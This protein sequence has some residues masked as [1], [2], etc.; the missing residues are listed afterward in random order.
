MKKIKKDEFVKAK[1][2]IKLTTGDVIK[3]LRE[4]KGWTQK[5]LAKK[6]GITDTNISFLE[7]KKIEIGKKRAEQLS[8][9]F[10]VHPA[11]ILFPEFE[12]IEI[13]KAA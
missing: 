10:A 11:I 4:L 8:K 13:G 3:M 5:Y 6:S 12:Q 9:A 7:N 1:A 2:H